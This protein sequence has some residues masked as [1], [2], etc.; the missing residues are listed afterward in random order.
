[1]LGSLVSYIDP[2]NVPS[3]KLAES[4][5]AAYEKTIDLPGEGIHSV[6]RYF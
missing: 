1:M 2:G 4:L 6:Y 5:G 3:I